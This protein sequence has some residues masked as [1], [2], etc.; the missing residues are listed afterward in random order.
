MTLDDISSTSS[1]ISTQNL[2]LILDKLK[3]N[4]NRNSTSKN[5]YSIWKHLN[6]FLSRIDYIPEFWEDRVALFIA[7]LVNY[8]KVQ[9]ATVRSYIS[10]IKTVLCTDG[11]PW[12]D[13][14]IWFNALIKSCKLANDQIKIRFPIHLGLLETLLFEIERDES[15]SNQP[16]LTTMYKAIF[17]LSYYG[18]M[19][20]GEVTE[21]DHVVKAKDILIADNKHKIKLILYSSKTHDKESRPQQ[22]KI[23]ARENTGRRKP[24]FC[25]FEA[26]QVYMAIRRPYTTDSEQLF[27][28]SD[29]TPVTQ[30]H[31]RNMLNKLLKKINLNPEH[32]NTMS[33]R[34]G[35]A[36]D[37]L[38]WG[39]DIETIKRLG[40]RKSNV[41]YKYLRQI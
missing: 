9:S 7:Y 38:R 30:T 1:K 31:V 27:V 41:V 6:K 13:D 33:F 34:I 24:H 18:L 17:L 2:R 36:T 20:I 23:S 37:L 16:Y 3:A 14:K 39:V 22:I 28:L 29:G 26:L 10:A 21:G 32:Y 25:P 12:S 4:Q 5:Y 40:R 11:Y 15:L 8:R 19:R 35:R